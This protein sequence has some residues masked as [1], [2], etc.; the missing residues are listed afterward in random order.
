MEEK[1]H[2][3][4]K[5]QWQLYRD[6]S[7]KWHG[8]L[9]KMQNEEKVYYLEF[10]NSCGFCVAHKDVCERCPL[11]NAS[12]NVAY[13]YS[14]PSQIPSIA[15]LALL[16]ADTGNFTV[17]A[18]LAQKLLLKIDEELG[19]RRLIRGGEK[20]RYKKRGE[21]I[22]EYPMNTPW[23]AVQNAQKL[24]E[25][26]Y[27]LST[28]SH[29]GI[30]LSPDR[31]LEIGKRSKFLDSAEFWEEDCDWAVPVSFFSKAILDWN[32]SLSDLIDD[33]RGLIQS[34]PWYYKY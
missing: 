14:N 4:N 8:I 28:A 19:L 12:D 23:G 22:M 13:C 3:R 26:I 31:R 30:Y 5:E 2:K 24:A 6:S 29:G 25:G 7:S 20:R 21:G 34:D 9:R 15:Y 33:A 16:A 10:W 32:P 17:A 18:E 11:Y 1:T 27:F